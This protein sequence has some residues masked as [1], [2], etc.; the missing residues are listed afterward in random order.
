MGKGR[1]TGFYQVSTDSMQ[2]YGKSS[3]PVSADNLAELLVS[4][5]WQMIH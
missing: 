1:E 5:N 4:I 3:T 2:D